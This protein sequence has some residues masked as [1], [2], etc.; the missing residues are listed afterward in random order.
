LLRDHLLGEVLARQ[1]KADLRELWHPPSS[2]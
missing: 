1:I 2:D